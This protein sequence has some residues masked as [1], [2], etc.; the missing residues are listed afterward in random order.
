MDYLSAMSYS[1]IAAKQHVSTGTVANVVADLK[2]GRFPEVGEIGEHIEQLK[3]L[4]IDLKRANLTPGKCALGLLVLARINECRL[5]PADIDRWPLILK[6]ITNEDEAQQFVRLVYSI[7][8]V[9]KRT[10]LSLDALDDKAHELEKKTAE[11]EPV[12]EKVA[13]CKKQVADI[14]K[15]R[16]ELSSAVANLEEK[17][18]SLTSQVKDLEKREKALTSRVAEMEPRA[19]KAETTLST[20]N[21]ELKKLQDAGLTL[22]ELAEFNKKLMVI[23]RRHSIKPDDLRSH[24]LHELEI[25]DKGLGLEALLKVRQVELN[26]VEQAIGERK[27]EVETTKIVVNRLKQEKTNL[28]AEITETR[29]QVSQEIAKII[30]IARDTVAQL[31]QELKTG[32]TNALAGV[33]QLRDQSLEVGREV[34]RFQEILKTNAWL[35]ELLTLVNGGQRI[36]AKEVRATVLLIIRGVRNW[37][38]T[39]D[40]YSPTFMTLS[41]AVNNLLGV[42]EQWKV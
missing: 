22:E 38:T 21:G 19:K 29:K 31:T 10:G 41:T 9:Q 1:E 30:P 6:S 35:K 36:E 7:Q 28:D 26:T 40:K 14:T 34:G 24:L 5:D 16:K 25:M 4:S 33:G 27:K 20:L 32:V 17:R 18:K 11:L 2:A 3:E 23:A 15:Q 42:L 8:E 13:D 12:A 39:Q 37:L